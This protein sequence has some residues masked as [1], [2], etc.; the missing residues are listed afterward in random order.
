MSEQFTFAD[1]PGSDGAT[2]FDTYILMGSN[3]ELMAIEKFA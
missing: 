3:E 1:S 2:P